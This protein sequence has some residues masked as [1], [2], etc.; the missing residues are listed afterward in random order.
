MKAVT[1]QGYRKVE[2]A[3][4]AAP[5][6]QDPEDIIV[7]VTRSGLCGSDLHLY[8]GMIPSLERGYVLGHETIGIV[9]ETGRAVHKVKKHDRVVIPFNVACGKCR[10]C[11]SQLE[12]LCDE[13]NA[14]GEIG[15]AFGYSRLLGDYPGSQAQY[16]RVPYG[17]FMPFVV[18]EA[19]ELP[20][21]Q[22]V[23]LSD[24]LPSALWSVRYAGV[25][26]GDT[27]IVLG[28]GQIGLLV[29]KYAWLYG[30]SRVICV[31]PVEYRAEHAKRTNGV[32]THTEIRA[33]E[34]GPYLL[35]KTSGGADVV[36]DCVGMDGKKN[37]LES[38]ETALRLQGGAE[39]AIRSA[40]QM[41][42]KGG[43]IQLTGVYGLRYNSFPLGD[44]FA[45]GVT[46]KMGQASVLHLVPQVYD[47]LARGRVDP[48]DL[49]THKLPIDAAPHA[50]DI[51]LHKK[52]QCIK[53]VMCPN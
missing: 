40:A 3:S 15:S 21:D 47:D 49:L 13:S 35:E 26:P 14:E 29:Q 9:E 53:I 27:V 50:Y 45:R 16:L 44:L 1:Y 11:A 32:E 36:I 4:V 39:G 22:L 6:I 42:R 41:V 2:V 10:F 18:P 31:E 25:K 43:T 24:A 20:D 8:N 52:E 17:N 34:I 5:T 33:E 12:S 37:L 7:R 23:M 38:V 28:A 46:L 48:S 51:F 30:A 19:C